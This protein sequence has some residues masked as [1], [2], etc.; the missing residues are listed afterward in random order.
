MTRKFTIRVDLDL[1]VGNGICRDEAPDVF[2][3]NDAAQSVVVEG[4]SEL[5]P[6][7]ELLRIAGECP[8]NAIFVEDA[9]TGERLG[10]GDTHL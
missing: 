4:G 9:D 2:I 8:V 5:K 6:L 3:A 10:D 7:N 1:C